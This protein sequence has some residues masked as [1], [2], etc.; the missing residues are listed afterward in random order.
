[1][2][3]RRRRQGGSAARRAAVANAAVVHHPEI[4]R[5][6]PIMEVTNQEGVEL[7]H[8]FAMRVAEEIG[9]DFQDQECLDYWRQTG[10]E[11]DG[12]RVRIGRDELLALVA[13]I[14]SSYIHHARNPERSVKVGDGH[15]VVSPAYGAP[16][17]RD[18]EGV[19]L[20]ATIDDLNQ[21]QKLNHMASTVH[22]A[23][24]PIVEPVDIPVPYRHMN[25]LRMV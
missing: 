8:D 14:P 9:C 12:E 25:S 5:G 17:V 13:K 20:Y 1:M 4:R 16:F 11:I 24:G 19:R 2:A 21:L 23:G 18:M 10:A 7:I 6:I 3:T 22:I 15:A